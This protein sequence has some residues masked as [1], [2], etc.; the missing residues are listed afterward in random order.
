[1]SADIVLKVRRHYDGMPLPTK[2]H[3]SDAGFD[4][5]AMALEKLRPRVFS[6]DTGV[7]LEVE[8]GFYCEVV[9]RSGIV[10]SDF[11]QANGVGVI[12]P[13]Y[14]GRVM[15]VLRYLGEGDG[16][17]QARELVGQR[18][19][20]LLVRRLEPVRV[21]AAEELMETGRGDGGFGSTGK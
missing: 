16:A 14:R 10:K 2:A 11:M 4:L 19:A 5:T 12:D 7:S 21:V 8:D 3:R 1:M 6:F 15:V 13:D 20:Q 17:A 18:I 9:P